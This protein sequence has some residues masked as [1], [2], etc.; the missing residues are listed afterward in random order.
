VS[1]LQ[2]CEVSVA[3]TSGRTHF[4]KTHP[5]LKSEHV[6]PDYIHQPYGHGVGM[7]LFGLGGPHNKSLLLIFRVWR[8]VATSMHT[9]LHRVQPYPWPALAD[10]S[11]TT[12]RIVCPNYGNQFWTVVV[13]LYLRRMATTSN[14]LIVA[15]TSP[16]GE[17]IRKLISSTCSYNKAIRCWWGSQV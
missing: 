1:F 15:R 16:C 4:R 2:D 5:K 12:C 7:S 11:V 14:C 9:L 8:P 13:L 10:V 3:S 6:L 17:V